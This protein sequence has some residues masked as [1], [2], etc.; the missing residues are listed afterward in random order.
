MTLLEA[1]EKLGIPEFSEKIAMS[2]SRGELF[3]LYDYVK[4]S[5]IVPDNTSAFRKCFLRMVEDAKSW[6][7]P[8]SVFQHLN[9]GIAIASM[10]LGI[11]GDQL[12]DPVKQMLSA[13]A[14]LEQLISMFAPRSKEHKLLSGKLKQLTKAIDTNT[15]TTT[16]A[17]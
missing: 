10:Q 8:E 14:E 12:V 7:R 13:K 4:W 9:R 5:E 6:S 17:K 15:R 2:N 16:V 3:H 1:C 11:S